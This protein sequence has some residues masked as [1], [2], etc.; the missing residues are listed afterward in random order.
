MATITLDVRLLDVDG[1]DI[2]DPS[3]TIRLEASSS[4][5]ATRTVLDVRGAPVLAR[6]AAPADTAL[7]VRISPS[8]Y[9]DGGRV[10][11]VSNERLTLPALTLP[12]GPSHW[13]PTFA[14]WAALPAEMDSTKALLVKSKRFQLGRGSTADEISEARYDAVDA[15]DESRAMAKMCLLNLCSR[16]R[17][18]TIPGGAGT[19]IDAFE[20]CL[21]AQRDRCFARVSRTFFERVQQLASKSAGGYKRSNAENHRGRV[22]EVPGVEHVGAMFSIKSGEA[23]ANIQ[24][25]VAE[26][27][28][29]GG[30][31][32]LLDAD[33]D[34]QGTLLGHTFE[35]IRNFISDHE[36]HPIDVHESLRKAFA[37]APIGFLLEP[38]RP[39]AEVTARVVDARIAG[40]RA[41]GVAPVALVPSGA[42]T[43][44]RIAVLGDSV[45][46][47]QG[48]LRA[49]KM[50]ELVADAYGGQGP[51]PV[52]TLVAHSGAVIGVGMPSTGAV[53]DGEVPKGRPTIL[54]Q[55]AAFDAAE[56]RSTDLV[57]ING[58]I[59]D[60]DVRVIVS[61]FT[62]PTTLADRTARACGDD[63]TA[64]LRAALAK[65]PKARIAVLT[66]YP[67]LSPLSRFGEG[68]QFV[69]ALGAPPPLALAPGVAAPSLSLWDNTVANCRVFHEASTAAIRRAVMAANAGPG[70]GRCVVVD[71]GFTDEHAALAPEARLFGINWDFSPQDPVA[72]QR[73]QACDRCETDVIR[74]EQCYRAS[75]GHPNPTGAEAYAQA[76]VA[77]VSAA[78]T[79]TAVRGRG[80]RSSAA[81]T[82]VRTGRS[83]RS[84]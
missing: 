51:R 10:G 6:I 44:K 28:F 17:E 14:S 73:R 43:P 67:I 58:G 11:L 77:A 25:T 32:F 72:H 37:T 76:I 19:W 84:G 52:T 21:L 56:A 30:P 3:V 2:N 66:Y 79:A 27:T 68:L 36:T 16:L 4:P 7:K 9:R 20:E 33:I 55:V 34:E 31:A 71:P 70:R 65:F 40:A 1:H 82:R 59:N 12:R 47:G 42:F 57:I 63:L 46:W 39:V 22:A 50:H 81:R 45:P 26:V 62:S 80:T 54:Q 74:R 75:A 48:L 49:Q 38:L 61:P 69:T 29:R 15:A 83:R 41:L 78:A 13:R 64:L 8:R 24:L 60:V 5:V 53:C 23:K 35:V 18:E